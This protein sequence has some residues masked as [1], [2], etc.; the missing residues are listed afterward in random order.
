[1]DISYAELI[2]TA[3]E[4][5]QQGSRKTQQPKLLDPGNKIK[6]RAELIFQSRLS[7]T[8]MLVMNGFTSAINQGLAAARHG[9]FL[10]AEQFFAQARAPL[11]AGTL[12]TE[13]H[14]ICKSF[15]EAAEA[16]LDYRR[17]AFSNARAHMLEAL[18][19]DIILEEEYEYDLFITHSHR[20]EFAINLARIDARGLRVERAVDLADSLLGYLEGGLE[21][22]PLPGSWSHELV[23]LLPPELLTAHFV[24]IASEVAPILADK[25][26]Q[27]CHLFT[28]AAR[29]TQLKTNSN[30]PRVQ[31]WFLV[32]EAFLSN[33]VVTFLERAAHFLGEGRADTPV[34]WYATVVDLVTLCDELDLR[35]S[36]LVS[37]AICQDA[38]TWENIPKSLLCLLDISSKDTQEKIG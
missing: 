24:T 13:G 31:A 16:Y 30:H 2:Q 19:T 38:V 26:C 14:L 36:K 34:L 18:A 29:H 25:N 28:I 32:K 20:L 4:H 12:S 5:Y 15:Q 23:A 35:V 9:Q 17:G 27:A 22:L 7:F 10:I 6:R 11:L 8:D 37:Q 33:E 21:V 3:L 1:M